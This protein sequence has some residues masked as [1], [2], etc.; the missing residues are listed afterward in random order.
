M[1]KITHAVVVESTISEKASKDK[2]EHKAAKLLPMLVA[3]DGTPKA[4]MAAVDE[5]LAICVAL[6]K[7][8]DVTLVL[9]DGTER[10]VVPKATPI[11]GKRIIP[12][13]ALPLTY[14]DLIDAI[15]A[16]VNGRHRNLT[17]AWLTSEFATDKSEAKSGKDGS[18]I[19]GDD[20]A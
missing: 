16:G 9:A 7:G 4:F 10:K 3:K 6:D 2:K 8:E 12:T 13:N 14:G 5:F 17:G 15:Q 1:P 18:I 11:E 20:I 19:G